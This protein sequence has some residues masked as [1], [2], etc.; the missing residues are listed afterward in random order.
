M[1]DFS[2]RRFVQDLRLLIDTL[3]DHGVTN[4][5][6][7]LIW[8]RSA[9]I[10]TRIIDYLRSHSGL[11]SVIYWAAAFSVG[12]VAVVYAWLFHQVSVSAQSLAASKPALFFLFSPACFV[13]SWWLVYRFAPGAAGSGIPQVMAALEVE[14]AS[15]SRWVSVR[16][17]V[18]KFF[19]SL[20]CALGGGAIGR[21]GPTIQIA[22]SIFYCL[23]MPFRKIWASLSH[24]ALLVAGGAA[25]I[26]AAFNTPLG[27]I[28][29]AVE[30][31]AQAHFNRFK[32][33]LISAVIISG[34]VAQWILGPY[35][36]F[37]YP[38]I[39]D[40]DF[41]VFPWALFM[42]LVC[43]IGGGVF[44]RILVWIYRH[45]SGLS[46]N[47]QW[48]IAIAAGLLMAL[49]A[50]G[51]GV[52][53]LGG[54]NEMMSR[55]LFEQDRHLPGTVAIG[56]FIG[57]L[58]S[59]AAGGAGGIFAPSLAAGAAFGAK[60]SQ[61]FQ[62]VYPNLLVLMG[63][64]G[65]LS[66]VTRAPFTAFVL[67]LEMTDRHSAI[68]P[69]MVAALTA[70]L[71]A[72]LIDPKSFYEHRAAGFLQTARAADAIEALRKKRELTERSGNPSSGPVRRP[73]EDPFPP[74]D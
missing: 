13:L 58:I 26:A 19:S 56:R 22:A 59:Y 40:V 23:G 30:E 27:G 28:V 49:C 2:F 50:W 66:A 46:F 74:S 71:V 53:V 43:G 70:Y 45:M 48:K 35:L 39:A 1:G 69:L 65:F 3:S 52:E 21:E 31:L 68:F 73:D 47:R 15:A 8:I 6:Q 36:Y 9:E 24:Q 4:I 67:V 61:W 57:P 72:R 14:A 33:F 5:R 29:F 44:G 7:F 54:G 18:V 38:K 17:A 42:G 12:L 10:S 20:I 60:I 55:I 34:L 37:G 11:Q 32:T 51:L 62:S 25:G 63:M 64:V 16:I 41:W